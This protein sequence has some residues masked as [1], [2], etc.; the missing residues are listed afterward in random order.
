MEY[1]TSFGPEIFCG[2]RRDRDVKIDR[3]CKVED[4]YGEQ[5]GQ[6]QVTH[7]EANAMIW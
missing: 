5:A 1:S 3:E 7:T 2:W 6:R 4:G